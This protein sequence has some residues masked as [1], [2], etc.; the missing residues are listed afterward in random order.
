MAVV[1]DEDGGVVVW[2]M[3]FRLFPLT[4]SFLCSLKKRFDVD[5]CDHNALELRE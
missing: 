2:E 5:L 3:G 1:V 4:M